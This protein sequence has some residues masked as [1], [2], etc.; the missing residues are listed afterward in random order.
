[1]KESKF[2]EFKWQDGY[3]AFSVNPSEID[4]VVQYIKNQHIHHEKKDFKSEYLAFLHKYNIDYDE[5]Y[6]W[7]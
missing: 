1:M 5:R 7:E 6:I 2:S 3:G 4:V